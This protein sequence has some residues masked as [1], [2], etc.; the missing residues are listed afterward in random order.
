MEWLLLQNPRGTFSPYRPQLPGQSHP[1]LGELK[2]TT[3]LLMMACRRLHL[4]GILFV[5]SQFH[6]AWPG[7][8]VVVFLD[9]EVQA[10]FDALEEL[11]GGLPFAEASLSLREGRVVD[12]TTGEAISWKPEPMILPVSDRAVSWAE[13][14]RERAA[15]VELDLELQ[16]AASGAERTFH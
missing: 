4:D 16:P 6:V 5:P 1:G 11:L 10:R 9:P 12:R 15:G 3:A 8:H 7:Q 13:E 14:L 2:E